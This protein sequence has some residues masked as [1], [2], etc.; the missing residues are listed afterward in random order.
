[1]LE[2][3]GSTFLLILVLLLVLFAAYFTTKFL[4]VK[5]GNLM[6]GKYMT[7][8]DRLVLSKDKQILLLQ[9]G[10]KYMVVGITQQNIQPLMT[11]ELGELQPLIEEKQPQGG[12][13]SFKDVLSAIYKK[14]EHSPLK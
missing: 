9:V 11:A 3:S 1:M 12:I 5:G 10:E 2:D 6:K 14:D 8:K 4:S 13:S 7:I